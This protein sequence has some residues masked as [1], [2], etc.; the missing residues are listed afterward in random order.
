M[1]GLVYT[2]ASSN[3]LAVTHAIDP[4]R[5]PRM[6]WL[7]NILQPLGKESGPFGAASGQAI[8]SLSKIT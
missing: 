1:G 8:R 7:V 5:I 3:M 6:K 2:E 4:E